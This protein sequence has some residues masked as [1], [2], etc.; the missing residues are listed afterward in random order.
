[1]IVGKLRE[2]MRSCKCTKHD[3]H[4]GVSDNDKCVSA[5]KWKVCVCLGDVCVCLSIY[6]ALFQM[7]LRVLTWRGLR[8]PTD[9]FPTRM[10]G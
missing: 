6:L 5:T 1:M 3:I 7:S 10:L 4:V 8:L 2:G 9:T